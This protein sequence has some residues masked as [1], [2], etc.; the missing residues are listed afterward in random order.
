MNNVLV[1]YHCDEPI[2]CVKC[3]KEGRELTQSLFPMYP[4]T[5]YNY[6]QR[7]ECPHSRCSCRD[8]CLPNYRDAQIIL[9]VQA[10]P[11]VMK[12][13]DTLSYGGM[14]RPQ[15]QHLLL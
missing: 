11:S 15:L 9:K 4:L 2:T 13:E 1:C 10:S 3:F 12:I 14:K 5:Y 7:S 6:M 8:V